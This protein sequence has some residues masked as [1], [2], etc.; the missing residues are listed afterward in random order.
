MELTSTSYVT[1]YTQL[2]CVRQLHTYNI[3]DM[4]KC[5]LV[6]GSHLGIR[7][8]YVYAPNT[9]LGLAVFNRYR[10]IVVALLEKGADVNSCSIHG[11]NVLE[12]AAP[13]AKDIYHILLEKT[14]RDDRRLTRGDIIYAAERGLQAFSNFVRHHE[15]RLTQ[16][17]L[18]KALKDLI[19]HSKFRATSTLLGNGVDPNGPTLGEDDRPLM[20]A[21]VRDGIK[22]SQLLVNAGASVNLPG[23]LVLAVEQDNFELLNLL[24]E[25]D[26]GLEMYGPEALEKSCS[27]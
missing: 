6:A 22:Y 26:A 10:D 12:W 3:V 2:L 15:A 8:R 11:E 24:I 16:R 19:S 1:A 14:S 27:K 20:A 23:L 13:N 9:A 21:A 17:Q 5:L 25:A 7:S 4:V 18:E